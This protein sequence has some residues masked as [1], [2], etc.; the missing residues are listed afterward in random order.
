[1]CLTLPQST[2]DIDDKILFIEFVNID[3]ERTLSDETLNDEEIKK[4][5]PIKNNSGNKDNN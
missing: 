1:M 4:Y 3:S 2:N 5:I